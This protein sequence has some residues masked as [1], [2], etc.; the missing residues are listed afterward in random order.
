MIVHTLRTG[1]QKNTIDV[2]DK[3]FLLESQTSW[4]ELP[5]QI[6]DIIDNTIKTINF[7]HIDKIYRYPNIDLSRDKMGFLKKKHNIKITRKKEEADLH[8]TSEKIISDLYV[9]RWGAHFIDKLSFLEVFEAKHEVQMPDYMLEI[10][11]ALKD[12]DGFLISSGYGFKSNHHNNQEQSD[13]FIQA[14]L[15]RCSKSGKGAH[16]GGLSYQVIETN[17]LA[18]YES[19][20]ANKSKVMLDVDLNEHTGSDSIT[21]DKKQYAS[22]E[23]MLTSADKD[24]STLALSMMAHCNLAKSKTMLAFL[25]FHYG[26]LMKSMPGWNQVAF[27]TLRKRYSKYWHLSHRHHYHG[28]TKY[29]NFVILL[30]EDGAYTKEAEKNILDLVFDAAILQNDIGKT[31][32]LFSLQRKDLKMNIKKLTQM[33]SK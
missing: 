11:N 9:T 30:I 18:D 15:D 24:N 25:F 1:Q 14:L 16:G 29:E 28:P 12:T 8:V 19:L 4:G 23:T 5:T 10:L 32:S 31:N 26:E 20:I 21:I 27:K 2:S 22:L 13:L 3:C 33:T 7:K 6:R 17:K